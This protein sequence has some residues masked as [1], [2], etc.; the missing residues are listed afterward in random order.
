[1]IDEV[2]NNAATDDA[3]QVPDPST[4]VDTETSD[5]ICEPDE[6]ALLVQE[7]KKSGLIKDH[8][9]GLR[10]HKNSF[11][12]EE[13]VK[14]VMKSKGL[15]KD[16]ALEMGQIL[17]NK[18]FGKQVKDEETF[19]DDGTYYRLL[20]DDD[21][22]ALNAGAMSTCQPRSVNDLGEDIRRLILKIYSAYL[23]PDGKQV[24]YKGIAGSKEYESYKK[25]TQELV[26]IE[27]ENASRE[28]K[29]AFFINI[30]NALVVHANIEHGPPTN[31]WQRYK[32]FN[33]V[34]Y[35]IGGYTYSLQDIENG[36][37][38]ANRKGV[39]MFTRPFG[40]GDHRLKVALEKHEPLIHFA[41]VCGAKS[42]PP[43]KT[44]SSNDVASQMKMAAEAFLDGDDAIQIMMNK[45]EVKLSM[46]MKWYREDFGNNNEEVLTFLHSIMAD[47][48][49]KSQLK[50]LLDAKKYKVSHMTYDWGVNSKPAK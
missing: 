39:G 47:G 21:N 40:K 13:F 38:R 32:F 26:R 35:V 46:I 33:T 28:E 36:V 17:I 6:Y 43:I 24:D 1:M 11:S 50:E 22:T 27:V 10:T 20:E 25:L 37:L 18:H 31:L 2:K 48:D 16:R 3:P 42:C 30:Y 15:E 19:K 49:K 45:K 5:F 44:Y 7:L 29:I 4:A 12:G 9:S 23:S 41:L 34:R 8:R 14:W